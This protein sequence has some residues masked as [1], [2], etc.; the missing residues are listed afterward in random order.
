MIR[1]TIEFQ[2]EKCI[3]D[4]D[5]VD[6]LLT[7]EKITNRGDDEDYL[8]RFMSMEP[9]KSLF[10]GQLIGKTFEEDKFVHLNMHDLK[11]TNHNQFRGVVKSYL[12]TDEETLVFDALDIQSDELNHFYHPQRSYSVTKKKTGDDSLNFKTYEENTDNFSFI[13]NAI[14]VDAKLEN[15]KTIKQD[16]LNPIDIYANLKLKFEETKELSSAEELTLLIRRLLIFI[17]F[18]RNVIINKLIIK[19]KTHPNSPSYKEVGEFFVNL[20]ENPIAAETD[21]KL[22]RRIID[23]PLIKDNLKNLLMAM[24]NGKIYMSHVPDSN[25]DS[26][27]ITP[28]R[29]IMVT[30]GFEWQFSRSLQDKLSKETEDKYKEE[31]EEILNFFDSKVNETTGRKK[32][33][34]RDAKKRAL[35]EVGQKHTL[36]EKLVFAFE[37]FKEELDVFIKNIFYINGIEFDSG[38]PDLA[39]RIAQRRNDVGHGNIERDPHEWYGIDMLILEWLYYAMVLRD[40]GMSD[41]KIKISINDLFRRGLAL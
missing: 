21:K 29:Y 16:S 8:D 12:I 36:A 39:T 2:R 34:Y 30:A 5:E 25:E 33:F 22:A 10:E 3:F 14:H 37:E 28:A 27:V 31:R 35:G 9:F 26:R 11:Q 38:Y 18:R 32:K 15:Q 1:G 4:L 7:I 41:E 24:V 6:F 13:F 23:F 19:K 17:T 20:R 40:I